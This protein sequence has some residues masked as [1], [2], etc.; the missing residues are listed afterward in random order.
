M[1]QITAELFNLHMLCGYLS[2]DEKCALFVYLIRRKE[3][4]KEGRR[5]NGWKVTGMKFIIMN[6]I[7]KRENTSFNTFFRRLSSKMYEAWKLTKGNCITY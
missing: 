2:V 1:L 7:Q 3:G 5:I 4:S 6:V